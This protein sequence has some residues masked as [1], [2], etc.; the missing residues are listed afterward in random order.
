M[1]KVPFTKLGLTK[2]NEVNNFQW[3]DQTVEVKTYIPIQEKLDLIA[4]VINQSQDNNNFMNPVKVE[5]FLQLEFIFRCTNVNFTDKQKEDITKLYDLLKSNG[6][7]DKVIDFFGRDNYIEL[8]QDVLDSCDNVYKYRNSVYG[9]LDAIS[10]DY[11][12]LDLDA[13]KIAAEIGD[14]NSLQLIKEVLSKMG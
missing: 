12:E 13:S 1:A 7:I 5:A 2:Q 3:K 6:F 8:K 11:S 14:P 4:A 10:K 9:I